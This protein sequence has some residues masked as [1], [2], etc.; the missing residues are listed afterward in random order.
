MP[1]STLPRRWRLICLASLALNLALAGLIAGA[2]LTRLPHM[3]GM[4]HQAGHHARGGPLIAAL[5]E[6]VRARIEA[7]LPPRAHGQ[8][9]ARF[10]ALTAALRAEPF[11]AGE[12]RALLRGQRDMGTR[13][14]EAAEAAL[15][16]ALAGMSAA[17]RAAYADR[18]GAGLRGRRGRH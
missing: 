16:D 1:F 11:D 13:R 14:A 5:P 17:E 15:L 2:V 18:L 4:D 7:Q 12:V 6:D 10:E 8:R 3:G 9:R